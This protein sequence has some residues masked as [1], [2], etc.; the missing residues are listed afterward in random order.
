MNIVRNISCEQWKVQFHH[1][2]PW[3]HV[4]FGERQL[5]QVLHRPPM[6]NTLSNSLAYIL[7]AVMNKK[8]EFRISI[9]LHKTST[10][11]VHIINNKIATKTVL[12]VGIESDSSPFSF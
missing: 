12:G 4:D 2:L 3:L 10:I 1:S 7:E 8:I 6:P 5:W 11:H 9:S